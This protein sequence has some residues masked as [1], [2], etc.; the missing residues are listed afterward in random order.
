MLGIGLMLFCLRG[1][2]D[3]SLHVDRFL[4]PAFWSLNIGP[5]DDGLPVAAPRRHLPGVREHLEGPVVRAIARGDP[6]A[7]D[8]RPS[9]GCVV[10]GDIVFAAGSVFLAVYALFLLRRPASRRAA[11]RRPARMKLTAFTDY[12]LRVL[13]YLAAAPDRRATIA[14]ICARVR[15]QGEPP[16]Q[17]G[18]PPRPRRLGRDDARQGRRAAPGAAGARDPRR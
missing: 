1:L 12:S 18:P 9:S 17:G 11:G 3:R 13:V 6:F 15:H 2:F 4:R 16:D 7:A 14:E 10:P 5:G 8:G